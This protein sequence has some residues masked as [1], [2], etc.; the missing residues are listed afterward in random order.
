VEERLAEMAGMI[1]CKKKGSCEQHGKRQ[2][3]SADQAGIFA[4]LPRPGNW[5][6]GI[7]NPQNGLRLLVIALSDPG[8]SAFKRGVDCTCPTAGIRNFSHESYITKEDSLY[9]MTSKNSPLA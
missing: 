7:K 8:L 5:C 1:P 2:Q 3:T 9:L 6:G 4:E